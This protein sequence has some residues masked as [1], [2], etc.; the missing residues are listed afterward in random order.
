MC[1]LKYLKVDYVT[2][3][4]Y[5]ISLH[6]LWYILM[7]INIIITDFITYILGSRRSNNIEKLRLWK[8]EEGAKQST[9][10][11]YIPVRA[12]VQ[13]HWFVTEIYFAT[14]F[15]ISYEF[16]NYSFSN[17]MVLLFL[18]FNKVILLCSEVSTLKQVFINSF[19]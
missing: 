9:T 19:F 18:Y 5:H 1:F 2:S 4:S 3:T 17:M 12:K 10:R 16:N 11:Q 13:T 8:I 6:A 7:H 15:Y 14:C